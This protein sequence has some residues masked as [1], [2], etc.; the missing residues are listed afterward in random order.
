[1]LRAESLSLRAGRRL[2]IEDLRLELAPGQ[3]WAVLGRNGAGKSTLL[4]ALGGLRAADG[5]QVLL[6]GTPLAR[7][8]RRAAARRIGVLLQ[9]ETREYW[10]S[11]REYV[12]LGC[13]P[14][15]R[16][17]FG[18][19]E[20]DRAAAQRALYALHLESFAD[21]AYRSLSGG[22]RQR[23]RLAAVFA[24]TPA[25]YLL[26]EP[27]QHLDMLHQVTLLERLEEEAVERR[28]LIVTVLHDLTF[29]VR[30]CDHALLLFGDG[31]YAYGPIGEVLTEAALERLYGLALEKH[32]VAGHTLFVP[33]RAGGGARV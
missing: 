6:E 22:E 13:Y 3:R 24:Q 16:S 27:L 32:R 10:G 1:M 33:R 2:L 28:A 11:V 4:H 21:R 19:A 30:Y 7:L 9:E 17:L 25:A 29:A 20:E 31:G 5:G 14:R 12:L 18:P 15:G 8:P 23:T 26:D